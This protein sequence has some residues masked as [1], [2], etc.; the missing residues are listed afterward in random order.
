MKSNSLVSFTSGTITD[1]AGTL[2]ASPD[3]TWAT[4]KDTMTQSI[5]VT[6]FSA[7]LTITAGE[8]I[9]V[10]GRHHVNPRTSQVM[11]DETGTQIK[12]RWTVTADVTL[13]GSGE[14]TI[15]VTNAAIFDAASNNQYDN[16]DSAPVATDVITVLGSA[17]TVYKPNL[18]YHKDAFSFATIELPK[19]F[20]TDSTYRSA[21]GLSYRVSK[22]SDGLANKQM[23]RVDLMPAF[24][25]GNPLHAGRAFGI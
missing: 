4:A 21:D 13:D 19:L 3:V 25:V 24:G 15:I 1:R 20:A 5:A 17:S 7:S 16:I 10:T 8:T 11:I 6:G 14:G 18:F 9:E 2:D 12:W 23:L 22:F